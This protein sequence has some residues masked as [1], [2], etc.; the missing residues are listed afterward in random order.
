MNIAVIGCGNMATP[1]VK[2]IY[3][4]HSDIQFHT[5]TPTHTRALQL[6]QAVNGTH[7]QELSSL[8]K[9]KIN[10]WLIACKPQQLSNL[11]TDLGKDFKSQNII[12]ILAA[13]SIEKLKQSFDTEK[14]VRIMPN[15][16]SLV[17]QGISLML[18]SDNVDQSEQKLIYDFFTACGLVIK[19]AN[20]K[21]FDQLTVFTGSGPGYIFRFAQAYAAKLKEMGHDQKLIRLLLNQLFVGSSALM[22]SSSDSFEAMVHNVSS[23]G[24]VTIE[25]INIFNRHDLDEIV[26]QSIDSALKRSDELNTL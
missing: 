4:K 1:I 25:A 22:N 18:S 15:T 5:Y 14:V 26:S 20:E 8:Q 11:A 19:L 13:T 7:H 21:E 9:E 24:G 3:A 17:G 2:S 16:P 10:F 23:K 6:A 12:S